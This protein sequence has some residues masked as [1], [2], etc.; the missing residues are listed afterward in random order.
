MQICSIRAF[1]SS[2]FHV[3]RMVNSPF[4]EVN[5]SELSHVLNLDT[6]TKQLH[7]QSHTFPRSSRSSALVKHFLLW[8]SDDTVLSSLLTH[9]ISIT[10]LRRS[11]SSFLIYNRG[12]LQ[13]V[14]YIQIWN[15][16]R[17][18]LKVHVC[19]YLSR[20][21]LTETALSSPFT[22]HR[23]TWVNPGTIAPYCTQHNSTGQ[24]YLRRK[25]LEKVNK[26]EQEIKT[27]PIGTP[28]LYIRL[29]PSEQCTSLTIQSNKTLI[30]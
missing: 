10:S 9:F 30:K 14:R 11:S 15:R 12:W 20:C 27:N 23:L 24:P 26:S 3:L 17:N 22:S 13:S 4:L 6:Y 7:I 18:R 16:N 19:M 28:R 29:A 25:H 8:T 1:V 21:F 5:F 2:L